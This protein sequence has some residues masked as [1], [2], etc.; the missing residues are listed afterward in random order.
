MWPPQPRE[1]KSPRLHSAVFMDHFLLRGQGQGSEHPGVLLHDPA[2]SCQMGPT[3]LTPEAG[4]YCG[5]SHPSDLHSILLFKEE[6]I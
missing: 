4:A 5:L 3:R 6:N 1:I 2:V